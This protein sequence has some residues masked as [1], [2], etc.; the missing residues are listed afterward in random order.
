MVTDREWGDELSLRTGIDGRIRYSEQYSSFRR[1]VT[2]VPSCSQLS[3]I[4]SLGISGPNTV[5]KELCALLSLLRVAFIEMRLHC[6][7]AAH[8]GTALK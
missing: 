6:A 1:P 3:N 5:S 8:G 7:R 2:P 4:P